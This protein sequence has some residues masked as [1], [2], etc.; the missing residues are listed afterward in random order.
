MY[1]L[2]DNFKAFTNASI[3]ENKCISDILQLI[4]EPEI[5][6][7][8]L[9]AYI[10]AHSYNLQQSKK[11]VLEYLL[12]YCY[13]TLKDD[14]ITTSELNDFIALKRIF[15]IKEGDFL[16]YK[17]FQVREILKQQFFRM[18]SDKYID[19]KEAITQVNLQI[20]FDLSYD[21]FEKFKEQEVIQ[22]LIKGADPTNLD[23]SKLP[24]GFEK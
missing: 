9:M 7:E 12:Q 16:K 20:M 21:E 24:R 14:W 23:I 3:T 22:A 19:S 6:M 13:Y 15:L 8:T 1:N 18:Y 4:L 10:K 5:K 11:D 2:S 17:S